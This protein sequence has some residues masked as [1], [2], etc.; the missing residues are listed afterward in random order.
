MTGS[1]ASS[2]GGGSPDVL[3]TPSHCPSVTQLRDVQEKGLS[4]G[5]PRPATSM[6]PL[7]EKLSKASPSHPS[8]T[9]GSGDYSPGSGHLPRLSQ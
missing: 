8:Q 7:R 3:V 5:H 2:K 6:G 1:A 4:R 9:E